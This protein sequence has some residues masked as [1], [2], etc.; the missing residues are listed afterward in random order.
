MKS[1]AML[2][3]V[4]LL[5]VLLLGACGKKLPARTG[6]LIDYDGFRKVNSTSLKYEAEPARLGSFDRF[7][8]DDVQVRITS[9]SS[10]PDGEAERL[11][12]YLKQRVIQ[13]L[14]HD[15]DLAQQPGPG[16]ARV[17]MAITQITASTT[18]L[19]IHPATKFT[20]AGLGG[21]AIEAE[22]VDS[23]SGQRVWGLIEARKGNQ[24]ELDA[25]KPYDDAEDA[26]EMWAAI[27]RRDIDVARKAAGR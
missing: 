2:L 12:E 17:R 25:F 23:M 21:A 14:D 7:L 18:L 16:V 6:F 22:I 10:L 20:G 24:V 9:K 11:A 5:M 26:A 19:S 1:R 8:V 15:Y 27:I 4:A 3:V 13:E